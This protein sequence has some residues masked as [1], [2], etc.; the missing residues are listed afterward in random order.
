MQDIGNSYKGDY[1]QIQ[2]EWEE[3][4]RIKAEIP[5]EIKAKYGES[6]EGNEERKDGEEIL[7]VDNRLPGKTVTQ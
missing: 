1:E 5:A 6:S 7:R 3:E 2:E 4:L